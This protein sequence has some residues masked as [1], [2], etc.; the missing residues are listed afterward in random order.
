MQDFYPR[1][2]EYVNAST[3]ITISLSLLILLYS[4]VLIVVVEV[5][6]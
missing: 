4:V 1:K 6:T 5:V 2:T 3:F